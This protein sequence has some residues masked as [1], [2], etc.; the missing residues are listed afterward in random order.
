MPL[1]VNGKLDYESLP[2]PEF[3]LNDNYV[4]PRNDT[5]YKLCEIFAQILGLSISN[6]GIKSDFF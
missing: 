4:A 2:K 5:D 3:I 6:I 1:T